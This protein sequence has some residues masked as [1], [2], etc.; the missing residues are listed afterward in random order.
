[1]LRIRDISQQTWTEMRLAGQLWVLRA[2]ADIG[3]T[4]EKCDLLV[5][6]A[7]GEL[8]PALQNALRDGVL[9]RTED[10]WIG[11]PD[12]DTFLYNKAV[13]FEG[14]DIHEELPVCWESHAS[15]TTGEML[16]LR[17]RHAGWQLGS[18]ETWMFQ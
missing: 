1:M 9:P 5:L 18:L 2:E 13:A 7:G 16:Y 14:E 4:V 3:N 8:V 15:W 10:L 17:D 6:Q 12:V 11:N